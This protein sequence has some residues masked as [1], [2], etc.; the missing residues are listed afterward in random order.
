MAIF[1]RGLV[2][3][4]LTTWTA[5]MIASGERLDLSGVG[6]PTVDKHSTGGV[7][8]KV[9]LVLVPARRRVRR[10]GTAAVGTRPRPYRRHPRQDGGDPRL[11]RRSLSPTRCV[12]V[13]RS[14]GGVIAAAGA[15]LAPADHKLYALRDVTGTVESI[16]LVASSIMSK[17]IAEGTDALVLDVKFGAGAFFPDP[18]RGRGSPRRW[19][20]SARRTA[21]APPRC[22]P[23]WTR[24]SGAAAGNGLEVTESVETLEGGGPADLVE[25]TVALACAMLGLTGLDARIPPTSWRRAGRCRCGAR[26][27]RR[28]AATRTRRSRPRRRSR[29]CAHTG[30]GSSRVSTRARSGTA[31]GGSAWAGPARSTRSR[32]SAGVVCRVKPGERV[33]EGD[34]LLELHVDDPARLAGARAALDGAYEIGDDPP[35]VRPLVLDR[36][37]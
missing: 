21:C 16:P 2:A 24:C 27:S 20:S 37:G 18:E 3:A 33:V 9:S 34:V 10:R 1:F 5:A 28:R 26:W 4:E 12:D 30:A 8:D 6:R 22:R 29:S 23:R 31:R 13:L 17:K 19:S 35:P 32:A 36:I 15:G 7:G 14:V 25:V 11:A